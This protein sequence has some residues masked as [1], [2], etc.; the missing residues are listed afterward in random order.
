MEV[1]EED[2]KASEP[3]DSIIDDDTAAEVDGRFWIW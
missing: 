2:G 3:K 1:V